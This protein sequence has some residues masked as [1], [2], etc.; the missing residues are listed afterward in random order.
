MHGKSV[1]KMSTLPSPR[2]LVTSLISSIS[3]A[4]NEASTAPIPQT[5]NPLKDAYPE[6]QK[7]LLTLHVLFSNELLPALDLLDR[8]LVRRLVLSQ[9]EQPADPELDKSSQPTGVYYVRSAQ[10]SASHHRHR[11]ATSQ[12]PS[13]E[14]RLNSWSCSCPA[15]AFAAFP[16]DEPTAEQRSSHSHASHGHA[17]GSGN[18]DWTFGGLTLG[19]DMPVCKHLLA[20][21][22]VE[23]CETFS[24]F[25]TEQEVSVEELA[26]W[27]AGWG[28]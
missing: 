9:P 22:L 16:S 24:S 20:C 2:H 27:T 25:A 6:V 8:G 26:G 28:D 19:A 21:V 5:G 15:F 14:V 7:A 17:D 13:Y 18:E 3:S 4:S 12:I 1:A 11:A 10:Q 23:R